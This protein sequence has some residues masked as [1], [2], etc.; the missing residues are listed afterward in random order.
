M[1]FCAFN[2]YAL[3][4]GTLISGEDGRWG[5]RWG[6]FTFLDTDSDGIVDNKDNCT[7][8]PNGPLIPDSGGNIQLDTDG[9]GY[10]NVCDVDLNQDLK[11][12]LSDFSLFRIA[13]STQQP[14]ADF[15]GDGEV[16]LSDFS[17]FRALFGNV[18]GPSGLNP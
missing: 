9:D 18:P 15:N 5:T 14:D 11:V 17:I 3:P 16:N 2:E 12:D 6:C 8:A 13:F 1:T 4:R 10:G 7:L